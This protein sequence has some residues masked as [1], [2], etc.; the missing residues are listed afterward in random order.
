MRNTIVPA[1]ITTVEDKIAGNLTLPQIFLLLLPVFLGGF[2]Y[3]SFP[4]T[5]SFALYKIMLFLLIGI[6]S[7]T[8]AIRVKD[9][10]VVSWLVILLRFA[11]RPKYYLFDKNDLFQREIVHE[12][13]QPVVKT[14]KA[15]KKRESKQKHLSIRDALQL[16]QFIRNPKANISFRFEK[17]GGINVSFSEIK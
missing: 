6:V 10:M 7:G 11:T 5:L 15:Q 8:L 14:V 9:K 16:E 1:Q 4:P 17:K 13:L 12:E 2:M 3:I